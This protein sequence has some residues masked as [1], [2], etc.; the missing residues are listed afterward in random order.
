MAPARSDA[1]QGVISGCP[2]CA[3]DPGPAERFRPRAP[4][5]DS[6]QLAPSPAT[7]ASQEDGDGT[8]KRLFRLGPL[9]HDP[10]QAVSQARS[11]PEAKRAAQLERLFAAVEIAD[12]YDCYRPPEIQPPFPQLLRRAAVSS[13]AGQG[14]GRAW[15]GD[16]FQ[17]GEREE[18]Q[19]ATKGVNESAQDAA[20]G[21][22]HGAA[23][24]VRQV[25]SINR[26]GQAPAMPRCL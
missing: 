16:R 14:G 18:P 6:D 20:H 13:R 3:C 7:P 23:Q 25:Q 21:A 17:H 8:P 10:G 22:A 4:L 2:A 9:A 5:A 26:F 19:R 12:S 24:A 15:I 1:R 11:W